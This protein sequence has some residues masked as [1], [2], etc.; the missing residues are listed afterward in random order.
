MLGETEW[1]AIVIQDRLI[2][3]KNHCKY[4]MRTNFLDEISRW[5]IVFNKTIE[6]VIGWCTVFPGVDQ[7]SRHKS[8][9][10]MYI[11]IRLQ[12][13]IVN[14]INSGLKKIREACVQNNLLKEHRKILWFWAN[15]PCEEFNNG[16]HIC[17]L[18][19][20][21]KIWVWKDIE[22]LGKGAPFVLKLR[23]L[24]RS[25]YILFCLINT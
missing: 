6:H 4:I 5:Y 8:D 10:I 21:N 14:W 20:S 15:Y 3:T 18:D 24:K 17:L 12:L 22:A 7:V 11:K 2:D 23:K 9:T 13:Q 1:H 25:L 19:C 16:I